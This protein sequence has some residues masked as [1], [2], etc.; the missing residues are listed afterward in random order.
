M[1]LTING[2]PIQLDFDTIL[3]WV[4]VGLVAGFLAS[5]LAL[6]HG[7]GVIGDTVVGILGAIIGGFLAAVFH[8]GI[9]VVGHPI[10]STM[11]IAFIG[12]GLLLIVVRMFGGGRS[13]RRVAG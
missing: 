2:A 10:I 9:A 3:I 12:A 6:G 5:H 11:I 13:R 1:T 4:L 7:L 8:I